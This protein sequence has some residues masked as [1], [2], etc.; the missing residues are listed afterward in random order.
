M[1]LIS[2]KQ[3][4]RDKH[5]FLEKNIAEVNEKNTRF[6]SAKAYNRGEFCRFKE[7]EGEIS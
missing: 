3:F 5:I 1:K 4:Y 7:E 6:S 2:R